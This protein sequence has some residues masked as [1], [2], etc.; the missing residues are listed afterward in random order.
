MVANGGLGLRSTEAR[1]AE[2]HC[3]EHCPFLNRSDHRC[4]DKL[5]LDH[6]DHA[7]D[8]CF[9]E[10]KACPVYLEQLTERRVRRLCGLLTPPDSTGSSEVDPDAL[11]R[12]SPSPLAVPLVSL[13]VSVPPRS[14]HAAR[15]PH[16]DRYAQ[17]AA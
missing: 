6:I 13:T 4:A 3:G 15:V 16:A 14:A 7:F 17:H 5:R 12:R 9:G 1:D 8:Y 2:D 10:Y 11:R